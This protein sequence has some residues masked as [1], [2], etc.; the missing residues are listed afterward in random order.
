VDGKVEWRY[1]CF[2]RDLYSSGRVGGQPI[3]HAGRRVAEEFSEGLE[4]VGV[5]KVVI[6][7]Y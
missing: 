7:P 1:W 5:V 6:Y 4:G 3:G 2:P